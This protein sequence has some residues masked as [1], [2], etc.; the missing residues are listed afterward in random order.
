[1]CHVQHPGL[2]ASVLNFDSHPWQSDYR[3]MFKYVPKVP[4]QSQA[5]P[6]DQ[7]SV[8]STTQPLLVNTATPIGA[9][10]SVPIY[11]QVPVP[12]VIPSSPLVVSSALISSISTQDIP[13]TS[14]PPENFPPPKEIN[15]P[16]QPVQVSSNVSIDEEIVCLDSNMQLENALLPI[17]DTLFL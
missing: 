4:S 8:S 1:M 3:I 7:H 13:S 12:L 5:H 14:R 16:S 6:R 17:T 2:K 10:D 11:P 9:K 15:F